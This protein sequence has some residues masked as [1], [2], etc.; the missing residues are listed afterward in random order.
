MDLPRKKKNKVLI[1]CDANSVPIYDRGITFALSKSDSSTNLEGAVEEVG[2]SRCFNCS[3]Y[4]HSMKDCKKPHDTVAISNARKQH[5][6]K[7]NINAASRN[8][9]RYYQTSQ[10]GKYDGLSPGFLDS[11]TRKLLGLGELDPP[12]WLHRM[13]EIGYPPGYRE[14]D[15]LSSGITIFG[16]DEIK[17]ETGRGNL[18]KSVE[19]PKKMSVEFPGINAPIPDGVDERHWGIWSSSAIGSRTHHDIRRHGMTSYATERGHSLEQQRYV[20]ITSFSIK[21]Y[22]LFTFLCYVSLVPSTFR[23]ECDGLLWI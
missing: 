19:P 20:W 10:K 17:K 23:T 2:A 8:S 13:R 22:F 7:R 21:F 5:R 15:N 18:E 11:E 6:S 3:S 9:I 16:D 14:E 4:S 1:P 12:P